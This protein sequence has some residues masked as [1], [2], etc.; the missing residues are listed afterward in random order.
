MAAFSFSGGGGADIADLRAAKG[1]VLAACRCWILRFV[2]PSFSAVL[3][4]RI[5]L[6]QKLRITLVEKRPSIPVCKDH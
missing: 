2:F 3:C 1:R 5:N 4:F 6:G